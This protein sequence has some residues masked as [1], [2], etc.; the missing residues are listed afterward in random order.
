VNAS[1]TP[2]FVANTLK[3]LENAAVGF[4]DWL[5]GILTEPQSFWFFYCRYV[6][7]HARERMCY[8]RQTRDDD[9]LPERPSYRPIYL[10]FNQGF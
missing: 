4:I 8:E 3:S 10:Q 5:D 7:E 2:T 9:P 1:C 6:L